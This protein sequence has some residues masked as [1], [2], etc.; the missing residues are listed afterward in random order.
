MATIPRSIVAFF[1]DL[2]A[3][4]N[5]EWFEAHSERYTAEVQA[6][7]LEF[8]AAFWPELRE[9]DPKL[10][11]DPRDGLMRMRSQGR[12]GYLPMVRANFMPESTAPRKSNRSPDLPGYYLGIGPEQIHVGGGLFSVDRKSLPLIRAHIKTQ[13]QEFQALT[14]E[15]TFVAEFGGI[16]G[17]KVRRAGPEFDIIAGLIPEIQNKEFYY[18]RG[19]AT[20]NL[21]DMEGVEQIFAAHFR[22]VAPLNRFFRTA[23]IGDDESDDPEFGSG[24]FR[25]P[26]T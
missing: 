25:L 21:L 16:Q 24:F 1:E 13:A 3:N 10:P 8:T 2:Q 17:E 11:V 14:Q 18:V 15:E 19:Y 4:N 6:P 26:N 22:Q 9:I 5:K 7:L 20:E 23:L 12:A